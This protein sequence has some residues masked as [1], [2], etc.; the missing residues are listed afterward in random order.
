MRGRITKSGLLIVSLASLIGCGRTPDLRPRLI[1]QEERVGDDFWLSAP[2]VAAVKMISAE[3]LGSPEPIFDG[4]PKTLRLIRFTA[5]V[6][7]VIKGDLPNKKITF[8]FFAKLDQKPT[9][10]LDP[11]KR[12]IVS[13][14]REGA[15]LRSFA[16][17]SQLRIPIWSGSHDQRDLP[18]D[19]GPVATITYILLTPGA[20]CNLEDFGNSLWWPEVASGYPGYVNQRLKVLQSSLNRQVRDSA[21]L[22]EAA[23]FWHQPKCLEQALLS[24][25]RRIRE[26]AAR[27][28]KEKDYVSGS[29][30]SN[31]LIPTPWLDVMTQVF[32]IYTEDMRPEVRRS[33]CASLRT[34]APQKAV[35]HCR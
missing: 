14:R 6:E 30:Q 35:E 11:G 2:Y 3:L 5:N 7:N 29:L 22:A 1:L 4:G 26:A 8:F 33:A 15:V 25:D 28:L 18:L 10:Y 17:A 20:D 34:L 12:Y 9:Y 32:E 13:L 31:P 21:C 16:D 19:L 24:P 27:R 23:Q